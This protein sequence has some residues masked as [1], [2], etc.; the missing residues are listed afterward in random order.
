MLKK[1]ISK[2]SK[3]EERGGKGRRTE[4]IYN[5][6]TFCLKSGIIYEN[7]RKQIPIHLNKLKDKKQIKDYTSRLE[8]YKKGK[9]YQDK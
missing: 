7:G 2:I 9:P 4:K 3:R 6:L 5:K 8:L 1:K